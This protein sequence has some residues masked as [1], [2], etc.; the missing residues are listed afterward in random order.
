MKDGEL[1]S[2]LAASGAMSETIPPSMVLIAIASVTGVSIAAL[3]TAGM[4]PGVVLA[5]V[6]GARRPL[7]RR[8]E[9]DSAPG[10]AGAAAR[11]CARPS[12]SRCPRCCCRS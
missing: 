9:E 10:A 7:A 8:Q 12:S 3:F 5:L 4:L 6:L 1:V 2:L 11:W